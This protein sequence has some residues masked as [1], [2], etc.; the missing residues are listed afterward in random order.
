MLQAATALASEYTAINTTIGPMACAADHDPTWD[1]T[2]EARLN[3]SYARLAELARQLTQPEQR[4]LEE[5]QRL[6]LVFRFDL[7]RLR[8]SGHREPPCRAHGPS[9]KVRSLLVDECKLLDEGSR[10]GSK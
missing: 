1:E 6:R 4:L 10:K 8:R 7:L 2:D 3:A 9:T 5:G